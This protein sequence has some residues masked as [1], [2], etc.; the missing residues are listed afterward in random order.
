MEYYNKKI[1]EI[2]TKNDL[3]NKLGELGLHKGMI[4]EV[5]SAMHAFGY[6]CGGAQTIVDALIETVGYNGTILMPLHCS[7]NSEPS[8]W[9]NPP[10]ERSL[11]DEVRESIPAFNRKESDTLKMERVVEN[12]RRREGVVISNH[13]SC[14][15]LA[16][17]KYAKLLCNRHSL[18]FPLS[19]ESPTARLYEMKGSVLLL[20]V[21]Y[22]NCTIMHLGEYRSDVRPVIMQGA[23]VEVEGAR[24]WKKYVDINMNSDEF[25][26][27]G[28]ILE[29]KGYVKKIMLGQAECKMFRADSAVDVAKRYFEANDPYKIYI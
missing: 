24:I 5:H 9:C 27:V 3:V 8:Y 4:V 25:I 10:I 22:D 1:T 13:P 20:G 23:A 16:W 26:H 29:E 2:L 19:E 28:K 6:V 7:D 12:L 21:G 11:F 14:A 18:H 15:Y 17:G